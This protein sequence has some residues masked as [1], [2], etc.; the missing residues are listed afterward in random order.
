MK[1]TLFALLVVF[2]IGSAL[3]QSPESAKIRITTWNLERFPNGSPHNAP[4]E[5]QA[6]RIGYLPEFLPNDDPFT[7]AKSAGEALAG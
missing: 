7:G 5:K 1:R 4:P 2:V 6:Q 3:G